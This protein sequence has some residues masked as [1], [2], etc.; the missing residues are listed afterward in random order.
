MIIFHPYFWLFMFL[1]NFAMLVIMAISFSDERGDN[2]D[3]D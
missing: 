2:V 3:Q 1:F